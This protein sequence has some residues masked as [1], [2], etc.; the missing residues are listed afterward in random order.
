MFRG[1][2]S[3]SFLQLFLLRETSGLIG[4]FK[5]RADTPRQI[6]TRDGLALKHI[7]LGR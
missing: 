2:P 7:Q 6:C 5:I 1:I 3:V 4:F